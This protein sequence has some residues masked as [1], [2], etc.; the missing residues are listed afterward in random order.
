VK[1]LVKTA[2][3]RLCEGTGADRVVSAVTRASS[4][5]LV[6]AYHRV[7]DDFERHAHRAMP[8]MLVS[9]VTLG[10]QLDW[11]A[12]RYRVL[13]LDELGAR[14]AGGAPAGGCAA[15]TFDDGYRDLYEQAVPL[16]RRKGIPAAVFVVTDLVGTERAPL[17]DRLYALVARALEADRSARGVFEILSRRGAGAGRLRRRPGDG[18]PLRL[19]RRLLAG[20]PATEAER[21]ASALEGELGLPACEL[22]GTLPL[23]WEMLAGMREA[24][25]TIASHTRTHA[26]LTL[27]GAGRLREEVGG[28]RV[29]IE[30]RLGVDCR[31]FAYPDG[32]WNP[33]AVEAV[34]EAGYRF[35]YT[36]CRHT[37]P[38]DPLLT[39]PRV[40]LWERA[41]Q[42]VFGPFSPA[43]MRGHATGL[44]R[45]AHPCRHDH[46]QAAPA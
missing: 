39:I 35:A 29:A 32:R 2:A 40:C 12:R 6:L 25:W 15:V 7:V 28:S 13:S 20:L 18:D 1:R 38:S 36:N 31:H 33:T 10:R 4:F 45:L 26:L 37:Q 41:T 5:P 9:A 17:H 21:A 8:S 16:L 24:G 42:G 46:G 22:E 43:V 27:E 44:F 11:L 23:T 34:R 14:L 19:T 3:A 30:R